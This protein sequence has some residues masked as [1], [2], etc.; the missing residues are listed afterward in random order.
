MTPL[1]RK[2]NARGQYETD[3]NAAEASSVVGNL[4]RQEYEAFVETLKVKLNSL[5]EAD[6]ADINTPDWKN[7]IRSVVSQYLGVGTT[8]VALNFIKDTTSW[9]RYTQENFTRKASEL[10]DE[11]GIMTFS[12]Y[13]TDFQGSQRRNLNSRRLSELLAATTTSCLLLNSR[14][15]PAYPCRPHSAMLLNPL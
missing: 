9:N 14:N 11:A 12:A 1:R 5:S 7:N 2:R 3:F 13:L 4:V 10:Q 15:T 8:K 6:L